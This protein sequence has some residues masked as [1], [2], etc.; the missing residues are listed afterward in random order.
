[1][2]LQDKLNVVVVGAGIIGASIAYHLSLRRNV[3]VTVLERDRP[4]SGASSTT[5]AWLNAFSKDPV[6]YHLLNRRSMD[7]WHR[8]A[9]S[10]GVDVGFNC[11]GQIRLENTEEGASELRERVRHLQ[12]WGYPCHTI[13]A[14][15]LHRLEPGLSANSI[16][17]AALAEIEGQVEPPKVIEACLRHTE[18]RGA[19]IHTQTPVIGMKMGEGRVEAVKAPRM[20][21]RCDVVVLASGVGISEL[22]AMAGVRILQKE[23]P[24]V[25]VRT[26]P[27]P[28][29]LQSVSVLHLPAISKDRP[30]VH[31]RQSTDGS[32]RIGQSPQESLNRDNSQEH[33]DEV[34]NRVAQ[35][36]PALSGVKAIP[37]PLGYRP[38]PS[39]GFPVIGFSKAVLNLYVALTHSGVTLAPLIGELVA[40]EVVD[41]TRVEVL[42][43]Y[44]PERF[45]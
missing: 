15:E 18:E 5:F 36:I 28:R 2:V 40:I 19:E 11:R 42:D 7:I 14:E 45:H 4:G 34:L 39:D 10:L 25:L 27:L 23:S 24:G 37:M 26:D 20:E 29:I 33:A 17:A 12:A 9:H 22:A 32:L 13:T 31:M 6:S 30:E 41:Q 44:R 43:P 16:T 38:M 1:M 35:Y 3:Q 21:I 8:F